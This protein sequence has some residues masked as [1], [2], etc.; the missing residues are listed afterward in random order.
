M[1]VRLLVALPLVL[2]LL[3][4]APSCSFNKL[5][6]DNMASSLKDSTVAFNREGSARHAREAAPALLKMLDGFLVSSPRNRDLLLRGAEMNATFAFGFIEEED[7]DWAR[8]LYRKALDYGRRALEEDDRDLAAALAKDEAAVRAAVAK[9]GP[10]DHVDSLFWTAFAWGGLINVSRQDQRA[11]ADL[12][13]VVAVME[14]LVAIAP[15]YYHSGPHLF[16]AV[17]YSSRGKTLGGDPKKA[18]VH[19]AEAMSTAKTHLGRPRNLLAEVLLARY[20]CVAW[21]EEKPA[22][23]R[24]LFTKTLEDVLAAPDVPGSD[25][26]LMDAIARARAKKLLPQLDDLILPPLPDEPPPEKKKS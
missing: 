8:E 12:P 14:R 15:D 9:V 20:Y 10:D 2:A 5:V 22:E 1:P 24:A 26:R 25:T 13:K 11:I 21:G 16:L 7:L 18:Y 6:A 23:A 3:A 17:Y 19:F 4:S